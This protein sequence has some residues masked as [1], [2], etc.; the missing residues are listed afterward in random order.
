MALIIAH[1]GASGDV[2][3]NTAEAF[4]RA[5]RDDAD[6]IELDVRLS[7]DNEAVLS[8]DPTLHR[9][10]GD[11]RLIKKIPYKELACIDVGSW[12]GQKWK[13]CRIPLLFSVLQS[14]PEN[15]RV[16]MELKD[17]EETL[18]VVS[19]VLDTVP[20]LKKSVTFISFDYKTLQLYRHAFPDS[21]ILWL[22]DTRIIPAEWN[23]CIV[24][25]IISKAN[26]ARLDGIDI[27][28]CSCVDTSFTAALSAASLQLH[29][30]DV[31]CVDKCREMLELGAKSIT[32]NYPGKLKTGI[33]RLYRR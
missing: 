25:E 20:H 21:Q 28:A 1:R 10:A 9:T 19:T 17:G 16:Y 27:N 4:E 31:D 15:R 26:V 23:K 29:V 33:L 18:P 6:G 2:P 3:E 32:T 24:S 14:V 8:H 30:W 5:W 11:A 22:I 13:K 12:K 7:A